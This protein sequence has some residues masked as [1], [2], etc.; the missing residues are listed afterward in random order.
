M[1]LDYQKIYKN[2]SGRAASAAQPPRL[3]PCR[4]SG[5]AASAAPP[6]MRFCPPSNFFSLLSNFFP[7]VFNRDNPTYPATFVWIFAISIK[8]AFLLIKNIQE[9]RRMIVGFC[10]D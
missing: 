7:F 4:T 3:R 9:N 2:L 6:L 10:I 5:R 1:L 8:H